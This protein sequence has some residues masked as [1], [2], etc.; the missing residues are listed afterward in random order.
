MSHS[1]PRPALIGLALC[2]CI[3]REGYAC[4]P[5]WLPITR[6]L[7]EVYFVGA[8][9]EAR[10]VGMRVRVLVSGAATIQANLRRAAIAKGNP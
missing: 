6:D 7:R 10:E 3:A 1:I 5:V 4:D 2:V 9:A 8:A